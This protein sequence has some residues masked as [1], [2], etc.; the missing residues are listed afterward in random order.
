MI[1][2]L[3]VGTSSARASLYDDRG[4][5]VDGHFHQV[6]YEATTT[7]DGGVEHDADALLEAA[8]ACID[9]VCRALPRGAKVLGVGV[10]TFWHGLLGFGIARR[11]ATPLYMWA[12]SRSAP[13]AALLRDALDDNAL[14][15]RTG[16]HLHTSYWPAKLRWLAR[17]RPELARAV[18]RWGSFGEHL[19][20]ALFG[21]A[22]TTISIASGTG[23]FDVERG[24]WD[25]AALAAAGIDVEHLFDVRD[26][27]QARRGLRAPWATR[28]PA[29]RSVP[30]FPAGGDG[31][32]GNVGSGCIDAHGIALNV[33]TS[34]AL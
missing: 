24:Q 20:A 18:V 17:E 19:E 33:G 10:T 9:R 26:R 29:L 13:D 2:A 12:D 6:S 1:I 5:A 23:L 32:A 31:A 4:A 3:D 7:A 22:G 15:A 30:W 25:A 16:C 27:T 34:A 14:H 28:W 8:A 11:P 21:E